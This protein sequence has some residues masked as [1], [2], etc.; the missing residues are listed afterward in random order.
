MTKTKQHDYKKFAVKLT[1][2]SLNIT[3]MATLLLL[4]VFLGATSYLYLQSSPT[5]DYRKESTNSSRQALEKTFSQENVQQE[6]KRL[7]KYHGKP[8]VVI[9]EEAKTPYFYDKQGNKCAFVFPTRRTEP[10]HQQAEDVE[11]SVA[12]MLDQEPVRE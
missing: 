1:V 12:L 10:V 7:Y 6:W 4:F 9:Y 8:T 5:I 3:I 2:M 11:Y